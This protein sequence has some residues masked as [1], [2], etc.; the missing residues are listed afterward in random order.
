MKVQLKTGCKAERPTYYT[1]G[2]LEVATQQLNCETL[3]KGAHHT[4]SG[5]GGDTQFD[6]LDC[7]LVRICYGGIGHPDG[8]SVL[9]RVRVVA[10]TRYFK[11]LEVLN[12]CL[13][14][15]QHH[16][17]VGPVCCAIGMAAI[18][19][20]SSS[21]RNCIACSPNT[22]KNISYFQRLQFSQI[23]LECALTIIHC[24]HL[25]TNAMNPL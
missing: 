2:G 12:D 10:I 9:V 22:N 13:M 19:C 17:N 1:A 4:H 14:S 7:D 11:V 6:G 16:Y 8:I 5:G 20:S 18:K 25:I 23:F 21:C 15:N 3:R 24:R